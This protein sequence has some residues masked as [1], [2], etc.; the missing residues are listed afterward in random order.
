MNKACSRM[1]VQY[2][3]TSLWLCGGL[4]F[5]L[6]LFDSFNKV[7]LGFTFIYLFFI[8]ITFLT[9]FSF[10]KCFLGS[11]HSFSLIF[12]FKIFFYWNLIALQSHW[13]LLYNDVNQPSVYKHTSLLDIPPS[14][15]V[16]PSPSSQSAEL[17]SPCS[18]AAS[19]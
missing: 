6:C 5:K 12:F 9:F 10:M 16:P 4:A 19:R 18:T 7:S 8:K 3:Y 17:S 1:V 14:Y 13:S 11:W 15:P 2:I